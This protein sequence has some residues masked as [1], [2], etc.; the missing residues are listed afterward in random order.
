M[1]LRA[2]QGWAGTP[3]GGLVR[4]RARAAMTAVAE[5]FLV[6]CHASAAVPP[7]LGAVSDLAPG[8]IMVSRRCVLMAL[9]TGILAMACKAI[10]VPRL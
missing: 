4:A 9:N 7:G 10:G 8:I 6:T 5:I 3:R 2:M 1:A